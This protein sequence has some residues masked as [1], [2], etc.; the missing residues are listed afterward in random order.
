MVPPYLVGSDEG[1][2]LASR[3]LPNHWEFQLKR[4]LDDAWLQP[5][6]KEMLAEMQRKLLKAK[7]ERKRLVCETP[8]KAK[9][10]GCKEVYY[11]STVCQKR[12]WN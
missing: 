3:I 1:N 2:A 12:N 4:E 10:Q 7:R 5:T 9:R 11:C 8:T 6:P